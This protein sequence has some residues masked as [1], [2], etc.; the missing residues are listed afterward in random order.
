MLIK[1]VILFQSFVPFQTHSCS[2]SS[3]CCYCL[4][5]PLPSFSAAAISL[6]FPFK[7]L[8]PHSLQLVNKIDAIPRD[9]VQFPFAILFTPHH[10]YQHTLQ[11]FSFP[12]MFF[13][14]YPSNHT[15]QIAAS[16]T[17]NCRLFY[18]SYNLRHFHSN[19]HSV[20]HFD[21]ISARLHSTFTY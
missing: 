8:T 9:F 17:Q 12:S 2:L 7:S 5:T 16:T 10:F 13:S 4:A 1:F 18:S 20:P 3:P 6:H 15:N 14:L 19:C 21:S 11:P